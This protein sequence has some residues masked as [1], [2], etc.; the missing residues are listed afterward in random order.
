MYIIFKKA[1]N[2]NIG[3]QG[4]ATPYVHDTYELAKAEA[5]KLARGNYGWHFYIFKAVSCSKANFPPV[6]TVDI[7]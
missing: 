6:E 5:E 2:Q 3:V 1:H 7:V 4:S